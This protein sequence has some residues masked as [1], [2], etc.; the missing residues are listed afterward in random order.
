MLVSSAICG[1][2][3]ISCPAIAAAPSTP[4]DTLAWLQTNIMQNSNYY[5]GKPFSVLMDTIQAHGMNMYNMDYLR[6]ETSDGAPYSMQ[7]DTVWTAG[8]SF[9]F[10]PFYLG[11]YRNQHFLNPQVNTNVPNLILSFTQKIPFP[12]SL[13][14]MY[15]GNILGPVLNVVRPYIIS[16]I[17]LDTW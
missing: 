8:F 12:K 17:E 1:A 9:F 15:T 4:A 14:N 2:V 11:I 16:A 10:K 5:I 7:P 13:N 3:M 6:A